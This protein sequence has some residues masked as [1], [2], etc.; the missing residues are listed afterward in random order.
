MDIKYIFLI[1]ILGPMVGAVISGFGCK[2]LSKTSVSFITISL[3]TLSFLLSCYVAYEVFGLNKTYDLNLY[4]WAIV[5]TLNFPIGLMVDQLTVYMMLIVT[6]VSTLVHIYSIGYMKDDSGFARFFSYISGF[7]FMMLCLVMGNNFLVLFFGW[8]GVGLFSYLL[9]GFWFK[10]DKANRASFKAFIANRV[11]DLGLLLGVAIVLYYFGT[12]SYTDVFRNIPLL[13]TQGTDLSFLGYNFNVITIMC[14]LLFVGAMGKS[15]QF[16][17]HIWLEGSM[18]GPTPISALI[19]AA[20]MVTAGVFMVARLSPMFELSVPALS[21]V[22]VIGATTCFFMGILAIVQTDIKRLIAY[23]TLS[24][25]G[26][27]MVAQGASAFSIGMFHLMTHAAFKALL[28]LAAGSVI[29]GMHHEQD[30]R[31]MGGLRK[32]MPITYFCTLIGALALAAIPP[33]SGFYSK[34]LIIEAAKI[35][36]IPG[37][38]YAYFM[39]TAC[40]FVTAFYTFKMFFYVFHGKERMSDEV[41]ASIK[42]SSLSI[43]IPLLLLAIPAVFSGYYF[44]HDALHNFFGN[45]IYVSQSL[46]VVSELARDPVTKSPLIFMQHSIH[47]L[48]FW[49]AI[50]GVVSAYVLYVLYPSLKDR[51]ANS[52]K[53]A[54][55]FLVKK[56]LIDDLYDLVIG[57]L[58]WA[59]SQVLWKL[60]DVLIIDKTLVHGSANLISALGKKFKKL[61]TGYLYHYSFVMFFAVVLLLLFV[62]V[63]S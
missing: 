43:L 41:K 1:I 42:E 3:M 51:V 27:M 35:S 36:N 48:P 20:T 47:T 10:S 16:P 11:G 29:V 34:D 45:S 31:K 38:S 30:M 56:Y 28:F 54:Y 39:V 24:Q 14:V 9:I 44:F 49:L 55:W 12:M 6:F 37:S 22:I 59:L 13:A 17:L 4:N 58:G 26:Y 8:E 32:Y 60:V 21:F 50:S 52:C 53:P 23:C 33:F 2:K 15:A 63:G 40:A 46:N 25:L 19:H 57:R 5:G 18:E 62:I 61:Q 7:T